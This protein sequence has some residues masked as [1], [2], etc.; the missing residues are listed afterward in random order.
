MR[1]F[2]F[3]MYQDLE[4]YSGTAAALYDDLYLIALHS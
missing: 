2:F 3:L 4:S 1:L